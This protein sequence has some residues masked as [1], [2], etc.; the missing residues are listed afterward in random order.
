MRR[1]LKPLLVAVLVIVLSS[2]EEGPMAQTPPSGPAPGV[3]VDIGGHKL[4]IRCTGPEGGRPTVIF[5]AGG[6]ARCHLIS[7]RRMGSGEPRRGA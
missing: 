1:A 4:H 3:L 6:P 5:E 7:L 2:L